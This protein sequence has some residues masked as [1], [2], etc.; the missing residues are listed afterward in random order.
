MCST[1]ICLFAQVVT[2]VLDDMEKGQVHQLIMPDS[3]QH[4]T[5]SHLEASLL[6]VLTP[7]QQYVC[8]TALQALA[9]MQH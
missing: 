7:A 2:F 5:L 4:S 9:T 3:S 8:S 6:P 1:L